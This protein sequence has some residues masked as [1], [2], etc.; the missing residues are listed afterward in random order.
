MEIQIIKLCGEKQSKSIYIFFP[1]IT[2]NGEELSSDEYI[3]KLLFMDKKKYHQILMSNFDCRIDEKNEIYF[4]SKN[5][6]QK[7]INYFEPQ[8]TMR[9]LIDYDTDYI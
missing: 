7:A 5:E 6:A 8:I 3:N 2:I 4:S 1:V 9:R